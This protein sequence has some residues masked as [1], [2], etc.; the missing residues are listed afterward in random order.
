MNPAVVKGDRNWFH[1]IKPRTTG[2]R[3]YRSYLQVLYA[4]MTGSPKNLWCSSTLR[5]VWRVTSPDRHRVIVNHYSIAQSELSRPISTPSPPNTH[6]V[7][8]S[9]LPVVVAVEQWRTD[10]CERRRKT[11]KN[12]KDKTYAPT[13]IKFPQIRPYKN[14]GG[15][16]DWPQETEQ[17]L[18]NY[19]IY[20]KLNICRRRPLSVANGPHKNSLYTQVWTWN[21][22]PV[23]KTWFSFE[24]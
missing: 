9:L 23:S 7:P 15:W 2:A 24:N 1:E 22:Q 14:H 12:A 8:A 20:C 16:W 10:A 3:D 21:A 6:V 17:I 13:P 18:Q 11:W 4:S 19:Q 5:T